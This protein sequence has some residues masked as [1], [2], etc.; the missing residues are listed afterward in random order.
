MDYSTLCCIKTHGKAEIHSCCRFPIILMLELPVKS[1]TGVFVASIGWNSASKTG[2][3]LCLSFGIFT[4]ARDWLCL[5]FYIELEGLSSVHSLMGEND[6][7][8]LSSPLDFQGGE[9]TGF[10]SDGNFWLNL[11]P[12][13]NQWHVT[14]LANIMVI[15]MSSFH[16]LLV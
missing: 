9:R 13:T 14:V 16:F 12:S 2:R 6:V 10:W 8:Q 1:I 15:N 7:Y 11:D 4:G 5:G 3:I